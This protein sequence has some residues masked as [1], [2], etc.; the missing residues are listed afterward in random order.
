MAKRRLSQRELCDLLDKSRQTIAE[1]CRLPGVPREKKGNLWVYLWP[2]FN[3]W[4]RALQAER[5]T[6]ADF[7]K[8]RARKMEADAAMAEDQLKKQRGE[9][10]TVRDYERAL[11]TSLDRVRARMLSLDSRLAPL[12]V[13]VDTVLKA[14]AIIRPLVNEILSEL[15]QDDEPVLGVADAAA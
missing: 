8:A 6:P 1:L 2:D 14:K 11:A 12:V 3:D 4:W 5:A 15:A 13:G 7:E 10:V 9:L